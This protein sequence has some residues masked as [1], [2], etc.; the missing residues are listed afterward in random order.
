[1][2]PAQY[3]MKNIAFTTDRFVLPFTLEA[4]REIRIDHGAVQQD[5]YSADVL[6]FHRPSVQSRGGG[7][8]MCNLQAMRL[9]SSPT[10]HQETA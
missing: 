3:P 6:V 4:V 2:H 9:Q 7:R 5:A 1:M 8:F 10:Q